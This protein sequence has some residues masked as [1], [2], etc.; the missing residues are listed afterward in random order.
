LYVAYNFASLRFLTAGINMAKALGT[1]IMGC[2]MVAITIG[3]S[4]PAV[5]RRMVVITEIPLSG[6]DS[7]PAAN[8]LARADDIRDALLQRF[9]EINIDGHTVIDGNAAVEANDSDKINSADSIAQ[10]ILTVSKLGY[11][12]K[13]KLFDAASQTWFEVAQRGFPDQPTTT[14]VEK[15]A[16]EVIP[17][18]IM[19]VLEIT[20]PSNRV[21]LFAD[22]LAPATPNDELSIQAGRILSRMYA[23]KLKVNTQMLSAYSVVPLVS[24]A[25]FYAWWCTQL[26]LPRKGIQRED[27]LTISGSVENVKIIPPQLMISIQIK[28]SD[29]FV[30]S[31]D[32]VLVDLGD[33]NG[34][35][36]RINKAIQE[37]ANGPL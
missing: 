35:T 31:F 27:T 32:S 26:S 34:T 30:P 20:Q 9:L 36:N 10:I 17:P 6:P 12:V 14:L 18:I 22:C 4:D 25:N 8:Q 16:N 23:T 15:I 37:L 1:L 2:L 33:M 28:K 24:T 21:V 29:R 11:R 13:A 5:A 19:R 7:P 3:H